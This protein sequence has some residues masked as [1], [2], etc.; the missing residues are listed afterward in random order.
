MRHPTR[1]KAGRPSGSCEKKAAASPKLAPG[2]QAGVE[3]PRLAAIVESSDDAIIGK[4]LSGVVFAWNIERLFGYTASEM[5]GQPLT[6]IFPPDRIEEE[7]FILARIARGEKVEH[8]ETTRRCKD[9]RVIRVSATVLPIRDASGG[10][11]G[12]SKI[13]RDLTEHDTRGR[14]IQELQVQLAHVQSLTE[15][16]Q[17]VSTPGYV[18]CV[19]EIIR[20]QT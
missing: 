20:S 4:D 18:P 15:L 19:S 8:Y 16:G 9:G 3:D 14:Q 11:I 2:L 5:I 6:L 1:G 13:A 12:A 10:I 17:V 7:T